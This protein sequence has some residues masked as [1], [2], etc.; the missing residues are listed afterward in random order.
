MKL[1]RNLFAVILSLAFAAGAWAQSYPTRSI[2]LVV[3]FSAG[4]STDLIARLVAQ[5]L[6][7]E[8]GQPVVVENVG[9]AAG[10]LGTM[11]VKSAAADGY[12]LL[13]ATVSTM[14]VY[15]A[16]HP[17]PQYALEDFIPITNM[18]SMPNL[19]SMNPKLPAKDL[20]ELVAL[21]KANPD[22][23]TYASS[24]VG[25]INHML[26]ES[27]Q[28]YSGVRITHVPYK[29]S[30]PAM[31]DV[32]GGQVDMLFDQFPSS[33]PHVDSGKLKGIGAMSPQKIPGYP[34]IMTMEEAG[35]KGFTDEAWYGL[36]APKGT[37][38]EVMARLTDAVNKSLANPELRKR[39]EEVGAR[40]VG[41]SPQEFS[42]QVRREIDRMKEVV[43]TRNIK[44]SE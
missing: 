6:T 38:A 7:K 44:L 27:F 14:I 28:A 2:R 29:G 32:M 43:K 15:P 36:L 22:K 30:G 34:N 13:V 42:A 37:P 12:T 40:P 9:G 19:L 24:G 33:K 41:N 21:L 3:P 31:Q 10:A 23:Y 20:K 17:K 8:L 4:G 35:M 39:I 1:W 26:G 18:A 5:Q 25:S 11:Q 16:A